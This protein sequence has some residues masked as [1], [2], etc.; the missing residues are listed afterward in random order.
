MKAF[1]SRFEKALVFKLNARNTNQNNKGAQRNSVW[2]SR[3]GYHDVEITKHLLSTFKRVFCRR[4]KPIVNP[5][6]IQEEEQ[7]WNAHWVKK[8]DL[9]NNLMEFLPTWLKH[10]EE[11]EKR[12]DS[13]FTRIGVTSL[14]QRKLDFIGS[15]RGK[16]QDLV[17]SLYEKSIAFFEA[18]GIFK[19][20]KAD[21][22]R[23][24]IHALFTDHD[25]NIN[26]QD[27]HTDY[28]YMITKKDSANQ[29]NLSWTAHMPVTSEGSWITLWFGTGQGYTMHI[30][31]GKVLLLRSD[32]I[33][34][35]GTPTVED[36]IE[37]RS[38]R[39]LHFYLVTG[40]QPAFPGTNNRM[41]LDGKNPLSIMHV[42]PPRSFA[43][44]KKTSS[45]K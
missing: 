8:V 42:Q 43:N 22:D 7:P 39:R 3:A 9:N 44:T 38:Y 30:P 16:G 45:K 17:T 40:D 2:L 5:P 12:K 10:L 4:L 21:P 31:F 25:S 33:H 28:D 23:T 14:K 32:V 34:G 15:K 24:I 37:N 35:G 36:N 1:D 19:E 29:I 13:Y 6:A 41:S 18:N 11:L 20:I 26:F 27:A